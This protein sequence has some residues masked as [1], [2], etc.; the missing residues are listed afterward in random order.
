MSCVRP[1]WPCVW[2][3]SRSMTPL[4]VLRPWASNPSGWPRPGVQQAWSLTRFYSF[5]FSQS[6]IRE[7]G[8]SSPHPRMYLIKTNWKIKLVVRPGVQ[9]PGPANSRHRW[10]RLPSRHLSPQPA[11]QMTLDTAMDLSFGKKEKSFWS[12]DNALKLHCD[13]VPLVHI[14]VLYRGVVWSHLQVGL[15]YN[16][17]KSVLSLIV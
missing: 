1:G 8:F 6:R 14:S 9:D 3:P 4:H 15:R 11:P 13:R 5:S 10:R 16:Q 2:L 12:R 17:K 7:Y